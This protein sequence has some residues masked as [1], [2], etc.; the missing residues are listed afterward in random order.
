MLISFTVADLAELEMASLVE[1][2]EATIGTHRGRLYWT[3]ED[4]LEIACA[5][6]WHSSDLESFTPDTEVIVDLDTWIDPD[7]PLVAAPF[8]DWSD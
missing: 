3:V 7:A 5:D 2:E 6:H 1:G 8:A 4:T